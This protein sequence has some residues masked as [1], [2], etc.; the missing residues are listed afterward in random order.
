MRLA[1]FRPSETNQDPASET[2]HQDLDI[3]RHLWTRLSRTYKS[4][5]FI[6]SSSG[7]WKVTTIFKYLIPE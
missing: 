2:L 4:A 3:D 5:Q 7:D 6:W 1:S